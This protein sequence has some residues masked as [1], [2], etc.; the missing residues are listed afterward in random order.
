MLFFVITATAVLRITGD[1]LDPK[2]IRRNFSFL[3]GNAFLAIGTVSGGY[4]YFV[5]PV[6]SV[7]WC[8]GLPIHILTMLPMVGAINSML[9]IQF[10][11]SPS[12]RQRIFRS[13][14]NL[15]PL[16][17][18]LLFFKLTIGSFY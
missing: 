11:G 16:L 3:L 6:G 5:K 13:I 9:A 8:A 14:A 17:G 12:N 18:V 2:L 1:D 4:H 10:I 7:S 15:I